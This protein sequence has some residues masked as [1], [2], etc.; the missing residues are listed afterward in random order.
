MRSL[1]KVFRVK[2][3]PGTAKKNAC[4]SLSTNESQVKSI[5]YDL[6]VLCGISVQ[7]GKAV[8]PY[9]TFTWSTGHWNLSLSYIFV[10]LRKKNYLYLYFNRTLITGIYLIQYHIDKIKYWYAKMILHFSCRLTVLPLQSHFKNW[11]KAKKDWWS[12]T[13]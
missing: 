2:S 1:R 3:T 7:I 6:T 9:S 10:V 5:Q 8:F 11:Q 12:L 13:N 4:V